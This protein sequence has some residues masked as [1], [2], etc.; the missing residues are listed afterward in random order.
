MAG[1]LLIRVHLMGIG[2]DFGSEELCANYATYRGTRFQMALSACEGDKP[3]Q[4][5]YCAYARLS[6]RTS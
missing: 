1:R 4:S 6:V 2:S 3:K 5:Q